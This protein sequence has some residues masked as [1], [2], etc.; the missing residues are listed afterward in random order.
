[1]RTAA[2]AAERQKLARSLRARY[3]A[4]AS[5]PELAED[6]NYSAATVYRL[7]HQARTTMRPQHNH[8]P[9]EGT[10]KQS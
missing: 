4:G 3:E 6:C 7:L 2:R 10:R 9:A 8:G 1:M 5:V